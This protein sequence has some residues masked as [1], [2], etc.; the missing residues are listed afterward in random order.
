[1][2]PTR[3]TANQGINIASVGEGGNYG[4]YLEQNDNNG[5]IDSDIMDENIRDAAHAIEELQRIQADTLTD[6]EFE[7][8]NQISGSGFPQSTGQNEGRSQGNFN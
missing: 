7:N 2:S 8:D 3:S 1:M 5:Q 6:D 4:S